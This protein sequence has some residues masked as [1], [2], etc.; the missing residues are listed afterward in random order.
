MV[1][2]AVSTKI[3]GDLYDNKGI[4]EKDCLLTCFSVPTPSS[5]TVS[6]FYWCQDQI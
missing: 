5:E 3:V 4:Q 1:I 2:E 6:F